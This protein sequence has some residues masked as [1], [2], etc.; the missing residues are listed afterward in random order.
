[1]AAKPHKALSAAFLA[2]AQSWHLSCHLSSCRSTWARVL[3]GCSCLSGP[4]HSPAQ[5]SGR[6]AASSL[7]QRTSKQCTCWI[8]AACMHSPCLWLS[9]W[10]VQQ[11]RTAPSNTSPRHTARGSKTLSQQTPL[12]TQRTYHQ[13]C[14]GHHQPIFPQSCPPSSL[15]GGGTGC[16]PGPPK[17]P[18]CPRG[19]PAPTPQAHKPAYMMI[20]FELLMTVGTVQPAHPGLH[21]GVRLAAPP[22][23][24]AW[25]PR[26]VAPQHSH[27]HE[28][29]GGRNM[30]WHPVRREKVCEVVWVT[31]PHWMH[32]SRPP[33]RWPLTCPPCQDTRLPLPWKWTGRY[34]E[35]TRHT[36]AGAPAR[37]LV[38]HPRVNSPLQVALPRAQL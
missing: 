35:R 25:S 33:W 2:L 36:Q 17:P 15:G 22:P 11:P 29:S 38:K 20:I 32:C 9:A 34:M 26:P 5:C 28:S 24:L 16:M 12:H 27:G 19:D 14:C 31:A 18:P 21:G 8:P 4:K 1:M 6:A 3:C 23:R 10:L 13:A 7:A 30:Q 37:G